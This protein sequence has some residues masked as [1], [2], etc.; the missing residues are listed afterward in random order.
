MKKVVLAAVILSLLGAGDLFANIDNLSNMSVEWIRTGNRNAATDAADIVIYNPGGITQLPD[1][2][3]VNIGNQTLIRKPKH[4]YD[5]GMGPQSHEQDDIDWLLPNVYVTY[6]KDKWAVFGGYYIPGGGAVVDYPDGSITTDMMG[7]GMMQAG[8]I[9]GFD[10][11]FLEA[12]SVYNTL[13]L[14]GAY[15]VNERFSVALG[16]RYISVDNNTKAGLTG[17]N[18][19]GGGNVV[20]TPMGVDI[21]EEADGFGFIVGV[22]VNL[23]PELNLGI[24]YL[25]KVGL[26]LETE[27][28]RDDLGMFVHGSESPRDLPGMLGLGVG[29]DFSDKL[30]GEINYSYWFQEA[31]DWGSDAAGR[32]ISGMAGDAQSFGITASY[33]FTPTLLASVGTTYTDFFWTDIN[34]YYQ[35]SLGSYEVLYTD[36]WHLGCGVAYEFRKNMK[37]NLALGWTIWDDKDFTNVNLPGVTIETENATTTIGIGFNLGF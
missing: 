26:D 6:N 13:T 32:D 19:L 10:N 36:N 1:G 11:D 17:I 29:Y 35:A 30:Y 37:V 33:K 27:V 12:E 20:Q 24:Q 28:N 15:Q 31:A 22:N 34:G 25:S 2:L 16:V 3:Q 14:G 5:L 21:D 4:S 8:A 7:A 9:Q 18:D 23:T